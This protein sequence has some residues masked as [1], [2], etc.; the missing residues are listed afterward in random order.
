MNTYEF[1]NEWLRL[2][3]ALGESEKGRLIDA[4]AN[5]AINGADT[6]LTGKEKPFFPI[7]V[8]SIKEKQNER[9]A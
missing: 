1:F 4:V 2:T 3:V 5:Y 6:A 7:F 8:N 9:T